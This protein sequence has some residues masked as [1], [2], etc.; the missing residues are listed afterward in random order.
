MG[1][2]LHDERYEDIILQ[3]LPPEYERVRTASYERRDFGLD[4]IRHS[5]HYVRRQ[6]FALYQS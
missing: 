3:A 5:T 6:S 4:G 1:Q 2:T